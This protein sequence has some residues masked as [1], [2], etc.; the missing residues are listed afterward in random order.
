[1]EG[2]DQLRVERGEVAELVLPLLDGEHGVAEDDR[3][4]FDLR[5]CRDAHQ[6][7]PGS[8]MTPTWRFVR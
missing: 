5:G 4:L 7:L 1:M 2:D 6:R 3:A 8:T